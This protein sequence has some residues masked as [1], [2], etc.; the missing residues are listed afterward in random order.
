LISAATSVRDGARIFGRVT[1]IKN[2]QEEMTTLLKSA[3]DLMRYNGRVAK[4]FPMT[5]DYAPGK[6]SD[7]VEL[8]NQ[9]IEA[10]QESAT[11]EARQKH[12]QYQL[13]QLAKGSKEL[14]AGL[15]E[16][17]KSTLDRLADNYSNEGVLVTEIGEA[18]MDAG[19]LDDALRHLVLAVKL[20]PNSAQA[21]NRLGIALRR[22]KRYDEAEQHFD[23]AVLIE[24]A[25][26]N[27]FFNFGRLYFDWKKWDKAVEYAQKALALAPDFVEPAKLI[28]YIERKRAEG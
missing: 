20:L 18:F 25:D 1:M 4:I 11:E 27:L 10:L 21:L 3:A 6:E 22:L 28:A 7:L 13:E 24:T 19:L 9:L 26:P 8:M 12:K 16:E 15:L 17:G 2:E 14:Q 23:R 5:I